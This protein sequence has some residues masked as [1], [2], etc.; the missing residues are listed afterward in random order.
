MENFS[1]RQAAQT[2]IQANF[3]PLQNF[4]A[5]AA[6]ANQSKALGASNSELAQ[7]MEDAKDYLRAVRN[8]DVEKPSPQAW[9]EFLG[10][11]QW[12]ESRLGSAGTS[13]GDPMSEMGT[14]DVQTE[15]VNEFGGE[16]GPQGSFNYDM[17]KTVIG[18]T[19]DKTRNDSYGTDN[20]LIFPP[21]AKVNCEM[22][23]DHG[24]EVLKITVTTSQ[25]SAV[26]YYDQHSAAEF[27]LD[28]QVPNASQVKGLDVLKGKITVSKPGDKSKAATE[29]TTVIGT[30][31][32]GKPDSYYY[33]AKNSEETLVFSP[34]AGKNETHYVFGKLNLAELPVSSKVA[35]QKSDNAEYDYKIIVTHKDKSTDTFYVRKP[36]TTQINTLPEFVQFEGATEAGQVPEAMQKYFTLES[37]K[38]EDEKTESEAVDG[39]APTRTDGGVAYYDD[40]KLEEI[41]LTANYDDAV[42]EHR[43][44]SSGVVNLSVASNADTVVITK[45]GDGSYRIEVY[46]NGVTNASDAK[47]R[48]EVYTIEGASQIHINA[49]VAKVK[50]T[51][52]TGISPHAYIPGVD[53]TIS[54]TG[55]TLPEVSEIEIPAG[56]IVGNVPSGGYTLEKS[57]EFAQLMER[58]LRSGSLLDWSTFQSAIKEFTD[59]FFPGGMTEADIANCYGSWNNVIRKVMTGL[60]KAVG[61]DTKKFNEILK[62]IPAEIRSS[63]SSLVMARKDELGETQGGDQWN[64]ATIAAMIDASL[65]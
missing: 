3:L 5:F 43:I 47:Y 52:E 58:A 8:G 26:Y 38:N 53:K 22:T 50:Y 30:P 31:V 16:M 11:M 54:V 60:F 4:K 51:N 17:S 40:P 33:E 59:S 2:S 56:S 10:W 18:F 19:G 42:K 24:V 21:S 7:W 29:Q 63:L 25:G 27:K 23:T 1:T 32:E 45:N 48:R 34:Q 6:S 39:T 64:S 14:P 61:S 20:T 57:L 35:V 49:L 41:E 62:K 65:S 15:G 36:F 55:E 44:S 46:K 37:A 28:I 13:W 9:S 12:A